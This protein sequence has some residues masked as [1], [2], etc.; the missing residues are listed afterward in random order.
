M[1]RFLGSGRSPAVLAILMILV[2]G[3]ATGRAPAAPAG[4]PWSPR[5][6][7]APAVTGKV[8]RADF[9]TGPQPRP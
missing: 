8:K 9:L 6:D 1:V 5:P 3:C 2:A 4:Q 7:P